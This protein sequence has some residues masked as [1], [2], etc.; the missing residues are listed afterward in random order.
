MKHKFL[1][2]AAAVSAIVFSGCTQTP[3]GTLED[4]SI[5]AAETS[6][7]NSASVSGTEGETTV[8]TTTEAEAAAEDS[9][10]PEYT[11]VSEG[12]EFIDYE[13]IEDYQGTV[14]IGELAD[15]AVSFMKE[16]E[17]YKRSA[18]SV[19]SFT[20]EGLLKNPDIAYNLEEAERRSAEFAEYISDGVIEPKVAVAY[21]ADYDGNGSTET[22][23]IIK[24]PYS[25]LG[26]RD[27]LVTVRDFVI[28]ADRDGNMKILD[29]TCNMYPVQ[30]LDYGSFK[31]IAI[32]GDGMAGV[33]A[34][35]VLY[36]VKDGKVEK[37]YG[38][39]CSFAKEDCFLSTFG[40][41][42]RGDFMYYDTVAREYRVIDGVDVKIDDIRA[43]DTEN[44]L[45]DIMDSN[46]LACQL[47]GGKYYCFITGMMDWG[48]IYTYDNGSFTLIEDSNVRISLNL[49]LY[50]LK[51]VVN[52]DI[53]QALA[54]MKPP[55]KPFAK[56]S[57]G[58]EFIDYEFIEDYQ[59][60]TDIGVLAAGAVEFLTE[61]EYY[62]ES[63]ENIGEFTDDIFKKYFDEA[64]NILPR[65]Q[66]AYPEDY[67]GDGSTETFIIVDMPYMVGK[68]PAERSFLIFADSRGNM[69]L[70]NDA[71]ALYPTT[72]LDYGDFK[73]LAFG[74]KGVVGM[75]DHTLLYSVENGEAKELF[76]IRGDFYKSNCFLSAFS[77]QSSGAFMYYDTVAR[78]YRAIDGNTIPI[79]KLKEMDST[80]ALSEFYEWYDENGFLF[81]KLIGGRYYVL[82]S[83]VMDSGTV[84]L[85][86]NDEFIQ[87]EECS[88]VRNNH[89]DRIIPKVTDIDINKAIA[90][91]KSVK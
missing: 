55:L 10:E 57:E 39:R 86:E 67:D 21:P 51:E 19:E 4:M 24:M 58:N 1:S 74:G 59:G 54:N 36:G 88:H 40:W 34:H 8:E 61:S 69:T 25:P 11:E 23:I 65:L 66:T 45:A 29:E 87:T 16:S 68:V 46:F 15:K 12:N 72:L 30:F 80:N 6:V 48:T 47:I 31:Q 60:T 83:S 5:T 89:F 9:N 50:E 79:E 64:G 49:N 62:A 82:E 43:M 18:D 78:E 75:D 71:S 90:E 41:Q 37:L 70:L 56:V 91:M 38:D 81:A 28:F 26:L 77:W 53:E 33:E 20:K 35:T 44:S 73:Q 32:G 3:A 2:L 42:G 27:G 7:Q 85:Y 63:T 52:I 14:D 84:Y 13:F 17:Q 22:F 76:N